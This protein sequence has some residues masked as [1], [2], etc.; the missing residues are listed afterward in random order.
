MIMICVDLAGAIL[1]SHRTRCHVSACRCLVQVALKDATK[2]DFQA[3]DGDKHGAVILS[4]FCA[5]IKKAEVEAGTQYGKEL[6]IGGDEDPPD[7]IKY[8]APRKARKAKKSS[9]GGKFACCSSKKVSSAAIL[10]GV[11]ARQLKKFLDLPELQHIHK[12]GA[13]D[14]AAR[15]KLFSQWCAI[16]TLCHLRVHVSA[17]IGRVVY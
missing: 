1:S 5:W 14:K 11:G 13:E 12:G 3:M 7:P 9:G 6:A 2:A 4:E 17:T 16:L 15:K 10:T 8:A